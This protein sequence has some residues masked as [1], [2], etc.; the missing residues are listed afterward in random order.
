MHTYIYMYI[1]SVGERVRERKIRGW[2]KREM[3]MWKKSKHID[4]NEQK[5]GIK[6]EKLK[7]HM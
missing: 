2:S 6:I 7:N 5:G 1:D 4:R 3:L